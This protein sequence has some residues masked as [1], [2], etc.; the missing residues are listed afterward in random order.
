MKRITTCMLLGLLL[1]LATGVL[2]RLEAAEFKATLSWQGDL[3]ELVYT[4]SDSRQISGSP[5]PEFP[6]FSGLKLHAGPAI[7]SSM[8][9]VN[10]RGSYEK[11]WTFHLIPTSSQVQ[12]LPPARVTYKGSELRSA[13][14]RI[15]A[16]KSSSDTPLRLSLETS[17]ARPVVGEIFRLDLRLDFQVNVRQFDLPTFGNQP[18]LL[19]EALPSAGEPDVTTRDIGGETWNT[20]VLASWLAMPLREGELAIEP[21]VSQVSVD[22]SRNR[23]SRDLFDSFFDRYD[24]K[25][26]TTRELPLK[27]LPLPAG[28]PGSFNGAIG[29]FTLQVEPDRTELEVGEALTV[30]V[31]LQGRGNLKN[32]AAPDLSCSPDLERYDTQEESSVKPGPAGYQ[33]TRAFKMLFVP[34][35]AG[36]QTIDA[37]TFSWYDP[38]QG[39]YRS[40]TAGP[41]TFDVKAQ[42]GAVQPGPAEWSLGGSRVESY[43]N[44]IR[45]L[46]DLNGPLPVRTPPLQRRPLFWLLLGLEFSLPVVGL[47]LGR[48]FTGRNRSASLREKRDALGKAR[49]ELER[50]NLDAAGM[51]QVL[52]AYFA[53]GLG[54]SEA[55][56]LLADLPGILAGR[57]IPEEDCRQLAGLIRQL[58]EARYGGAKAPAARELSELL[59]RL[60]ARVREE[61]T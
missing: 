27:V 56:L 14:V 32:L 5:Q 38:Q 41:W 43:G 31:R 54:T 46:A 40:Q 19:I 34:R 20:A 44:D 22:G 49:R 26:L 8:K 50:G 37:L 29:Q 12:Q 53:L 25:T 13:S 39:R 1:V 60:D 7:G 58:E 10:G 11:S 30:D 51:E 42:S 33:G 23:R 52:R 24:R 21:L 45:Y 28:A 47:G 48:W 59:A 35:A 57:G 6:K 15:P 4:L 18:G 9:L 55:G 17:N 61:R 3:V 16:R 2:Q 36:T